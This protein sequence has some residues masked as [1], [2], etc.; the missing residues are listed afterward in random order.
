MRA[1]KFTLGIYLVIF[2]LAVTGCNLFPSSNKPKPAPIRPR[3]S[4]AP[5][6]IPS[7]IKTP[8]LTSVSK[9]HILNRITTIEAAVKKGEW[10]KASGETNRLGLDMGRFRPASGVS[11]GKS[12]RETARFDAIY[13]KLQ[14]DVKLKNKNM[15][16][17]DLK[18]LRNAMNSLK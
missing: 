15:T 1:S 5:R 7:P 6:I 10:S 4:P 9:K 12:L 2:S 3:V 18:N 8:A 16:L 14:A 13:V 17:T 11:K